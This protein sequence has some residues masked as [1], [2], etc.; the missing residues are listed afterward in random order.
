LNQR[1][2]SN[3]TGLQDPGEINADYLNIVRRKAMRH[4]G[5]K[6]MEYLKGKI[7]ELANEEQ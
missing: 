4:F 2:K 3:C 5:N 7:N 6:K 1:S